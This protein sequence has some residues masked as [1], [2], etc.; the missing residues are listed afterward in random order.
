MSFLF[1]AVLWGLLASFI[2]LI[3]HL[4]NQN[5]TKTLEFSSIQHIKAL[6][7]E[8]IRKLKIA[9]WILVLL[10][11]L[12]II[13]LILMCS[14]PI[15]LNNSKWVPSAKESVAVV[16]IDNSASLGVAKNGI[17]YLDKNISLLPKIFSAFEG[18]TNLNIYQ[19]NP[20]KM[21]FSDFIEEGI[22]VNSENWKIQQSMGR[23]NLW[24]FADSILQLI[25]SNTPNK[26][27]YILSDFPVSP[28]LN[29]I[30]NYD[31]WQLYFNENE[32][33]LNN[34]SINTVSTVNQMKLP[35]H[36]LKLNTR[37]ENSS[38]EEKRNIPIEL[39]LNEDRIGQIV[40]SFMPNRYKDFLFQAY[41]GKSGI[42]KGKIEIIK[43]DFIFDNVKTFEIY[44][45]ERISC[46]VIASDINK[47]AF[48]KT[49]LE[50]ISGKDRFLDIELREMPSIDMLY[51]DQTDV[52]FLLDPANISVKAIQALKVFLQKGGSIFWISG[53]NYGNIDSDV[54]ENLNLPIFQK[55]ISTGLDSYFTTEIVNRENPILQELNLRDPESSLPKVYKYNQVK[56]KKNQ[57]QIIALNNNDPLLIEIQSNSSQILFLTSPIDLDWNNIGLKGIIVPLLH[58]AIILSAD[59][60]Y[61]IAS[62][63][64]GSI[65]KIKVPS[66][67]INEKWKLITP[68][69][70]EI[71]V[72]PNYEKERLDINV[73]DELG[74]YDVYVNNDFF[75]AFSTNLS[76][77]ESPKIRANLNEMVNSF[78]S[79]NASIL[80]ENQDIVESI[81]SQRHG[82]SLWRIFL[83]I[84]ISLFLIESI[85]SRPTQKELSN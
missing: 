63:E 62:V 36:L 21:L 2:P 8:S 41:P 60:E 54:L 28:Q 33:S 80:L 53:Q 84:S 31:E 27:L 57:N 75:T 61:N 11:T 64:V 29:F 42:I 81:K 18:V 15:L 83:I 73:T 50:S 39:Y 65:K 34:I 20:P 5:T 56:I 22:S 1:P 38:I 47:S 7:N 32:K 55:L 16:I 26:E 17:S 76:K 37:I 58:R 12:I 14:G 66:E 59:D 3:I 19:T 46:K 30:N 4:F 67:L 74:S 79:K 85:I 48:I 44:I 68:S 70:N 9:Q 25:N 77:F 24:F 40:S 45:P 35:N 71:L 10:R 51:L 82:K 69:K 13:C 49:A 78:Q 6:K 72:I 43:D 23:D 52:L